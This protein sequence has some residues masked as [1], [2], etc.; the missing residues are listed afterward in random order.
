M[1]GSAGAQ[2]SAENGRGSDTPG[3]PLLRDAGAADFN[4][5]AIPADPQNMNKYETYEVKL[6]INHKT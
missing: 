5:S 4:G 1:A 3:T 2:K 6:A